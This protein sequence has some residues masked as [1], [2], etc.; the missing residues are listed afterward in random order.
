MQIEYEVTYADMLKF[1]LIH[2]FY[3][4]VIQVL[5]LS[6]SG[7]AFLPD[8]D[9]PFNHVPSWIL[10]LIFYVGLW[11]IQ[12]AITAINLISSKNHAILTK[13]V[14]EVHGDALIDETRFSKTYFYWPGIVR[15]MSCP[16]FTAIYVAQHHAFVIPNRFFSGHAERASFLAL[17]R[18]KMQTASTASG[19][20][21]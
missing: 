16:G 6:I 18:D 5:H 20:V 13:H 17:V 19:L 21:P 4:P 11:V 8:P 14:L 2:Q 12:F 15:A 3:S 1:S 9:G 10:A 7:L